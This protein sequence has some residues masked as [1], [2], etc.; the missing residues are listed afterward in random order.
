MTNKDLLPAPRSMD[1]ALQTADLLSHSQLIPR[2]FQGRPADIVVAMMWSHSL[3]I[4]VVQGLQYI[5]VINGKP[6][7]YGDGLLAVV[8]A[9]GQC[10]DFREELR[11]E[12]NALTAIC[13]VKRRGLEAPIVG[14]FSMEDAKTAG[15]LGKPGPWKQYPKR[16]LRMRARAFALRDAFPDILSGMSSAEEMADVE[17][18]AVEKVEEPEPARKMPRRRQKAAPAAI[19][20]AAPAPA[21]EHV[22][23]APV[24]APAAREPEPEP[25]PEPLP[26]PEA[27]EP[28]EAPEAVEP[29]QEPPAEI[30]E[31]AAQQA[32][33]F[34]PSHR[35]AL[36]ADIN[37]CTSRTSLIALWRKLTQ[38]DKA[39]AVIAQAFADRQAALNRGAA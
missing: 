5:A 26:D 6:S 19:E 32:E 4:P 21:P 11:G 22:A 20:A 33:E 12:G 13:T 1:E 37:V 36:I 27:A 7:M 16:M 2:A 10:T 34:K 18:V 17:A 23:P 24:E 35:D 39:D 9:S 29:V 8:M 25:A 3:G 28:L 38:E 31:P 15:L 14:T 30:E